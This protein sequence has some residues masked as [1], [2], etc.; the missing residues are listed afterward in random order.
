[1]S[2]ILI[3]VTTV[4]IFFIG[5]M[6]IEISGFL[7]HESLLERLSYS[8]GLGVGLI[9]LQMFAYSLCHIMWSPLSLL[10]PWLIL[11]VVFLSLKRKLPAVKK[12]KLNLGRTEILFFSLIL[13][14]I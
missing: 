3:L 11:F 10:A 1:M 8:W 7:K 12:P 4:C 9:G 13:L 14:L 5:F 2:F 6:V